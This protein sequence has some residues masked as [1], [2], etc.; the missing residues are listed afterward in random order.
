MSPWN[1]YFLGVGTT[2]ALL[3]ILWVA[4]RIA[5]PWVMAQAAAVPIGFLHIVGMRIRKTDPGVVVGARYSCRP[6]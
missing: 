2:L 1:A 3:L 4:L 5:E 6:Y